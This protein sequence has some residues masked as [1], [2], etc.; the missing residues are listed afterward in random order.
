MDSLLHVIKDPN[1]IE[2]LSKKVFEGWKAYV[3]ATYNMTPEEYSAK[4]RR[5]QHEKP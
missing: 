2:E 3:K 1:F 4:L 5:E